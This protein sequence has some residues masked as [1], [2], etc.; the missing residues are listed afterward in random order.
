MAKYKAK[1]DGYLGKN[2][3]H[4]RQGD[5]FEYEGKPGLWMIPV[6]PSESPVIEGVGKDHPFPSF[7]E[8]QEA[9][10]PKSETIKPDLPKRPYNKSKGK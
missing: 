2:G 1:S 4:I 10:P 3:G 9:N 5:V 6:E 7:H 8:M